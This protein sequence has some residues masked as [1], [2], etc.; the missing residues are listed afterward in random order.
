MALRTNSSLAFSFEPDPD[1]ESQQNAQDDRVDQRL[2]DVLLDLPPVMPDAEYAS[3]I[4]AVV[5]LL[6]MRL[7]RRRRMPF[8]DV[9]AMSGQ[10]SAAPQSRA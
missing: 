9:A 10:I 7:P 8:V 5:Q 6:P 3:D 4:G 2:L 1:P